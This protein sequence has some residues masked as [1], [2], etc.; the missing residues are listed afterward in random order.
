VRFDGVA[1]ALADEAGLQD[2]Q[3]GVGQRSTQGRQAIGRG[4]VDVR[5]APTGALDEVSIDRDLARPPADAQDGC[6]T[7]QSTSAAV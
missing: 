6:R 1:C 7:F 5:E 3:V 2:H 4:A